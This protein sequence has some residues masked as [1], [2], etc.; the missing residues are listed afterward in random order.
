MQLRVLSSPSQ[1]DRLLVHLLEDGHFSR[2]HLKLDCAYEDALAPPSYLLRVPHV[3]VVSSS[4]TTQSSLLRISTLE[5][6]K[7]QNR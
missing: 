4:V 3:C 2:P 1:P 5:A 7:L 6:S